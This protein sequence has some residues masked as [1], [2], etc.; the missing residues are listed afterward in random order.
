[1]T[2]PPESTEGKVD[3]FAWFARTPRVVDS[4]RRGLAQDLFD[5]LETAW[6]LKV[7]HPEVV[8]E[9]LP[10]PLVLAKEVYTL[11]ELMCLYGIED[12]VHRVAQR[13]HLVP[14]KEA[15]EFGSPPARY[16][17]EDLSA[18]IEQW[19]WRRVSQVLNGWWLRFFPTACQTCVRCKLYDGRPRTQ[20]LLCKKIG[21][22]LDSLRYAIAHFLQE[23][24]RLGSV[25][26]W[27][28][29]HSADTW[30]G[31]R[32]TVWGILLIYLLDRQLLLLSNEELLQLTPLRL[33]NTEDLTR[34]WRLRRMPE[35]QQFCGALQLIASDAGTHRQVLFT[36]SL[37]VLL[38]YG[39]AGL[40]ELS[41]NLSLVD[42]QQVCRERR[43]VTAHVGQGLFLPYPYALS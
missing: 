12:K 30:I 34:L 36:L 29:V 6:Q 4:D 13:Y 3:P 26:A 5:W 38:R 7:E 33:M 41:A 31:E 19:E 42:L 20:Q 32:H 28:R 39:L 43:L 23:V 27:W 18:V 37:F 35:Y 15:Q 17:R 10:Q 25:S 2:M 9:L 1:M 21:Y 8:R 40:A 22:R 16:R 11:E 24:F 14:M